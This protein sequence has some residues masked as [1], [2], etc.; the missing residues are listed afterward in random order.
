MAAGGAHVTT[1]VALLTV[2]RN[3]LGHSG[4][5]RGVGGSEDNREKSRCQQSGRSPP[6]GY[7]RM[8]RG[9]RAVA[10]S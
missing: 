3:R 8:S 7:K 2:S 10:L 5:V 1:G 4:L 9:L 6:L